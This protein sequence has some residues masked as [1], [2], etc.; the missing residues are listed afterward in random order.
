M[1]AAIGS[2]LDDLAYLWSQAPA[3]M[4]QEHMKATMEAGLFLEAELKENSPK[5]AT[6]F[7]TQAH[8]FVGPIVLDDDVQGVVGNPLNYAIPVELGTKPHMP[9]VA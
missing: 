4:Q 6:G 3:L 5:G 1:L 7:Y 9:P 8:A 2:N